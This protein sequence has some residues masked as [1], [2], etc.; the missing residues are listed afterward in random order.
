MKR[1]HITKGFFVL[2]LLCVVVFIAI[3]LVGQE[4]VSAQGEALVLA[5]PMLLGQEWSSEQREVW[6]AAEKLRESPIK[7]DLDEYL[8]SFHPDYHEFYPNNPLQSHEARRRNQV[9]YG[10]GKTLTHYHSPIQIK[11]Y[12]NIAFVH[13]FCWNLTENAEGER[14]SDHHR[15]TKVWMKEG[16]K[17]QVIYQHGYPPLEQ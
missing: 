4:R 16:D 1:K 5:G 10:T 14:E 7:E 11:I 9:R 13:Y 8:S 6:E 17:W 2:S 12:G 15:G 3:T